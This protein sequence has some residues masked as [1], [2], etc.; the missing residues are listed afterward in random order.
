VKQRDLGEYGENARG[1]QNMQYTKKSQ[2]PPQTKANQIK[3][4]T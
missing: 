3:R 2:A 1:K 4:Q